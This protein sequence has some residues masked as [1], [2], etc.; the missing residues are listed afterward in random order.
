[1]IGAAH[2]IDDQPNEAEQMADAMLA[3]V[4]DAL[5]ACLAA[6]LGAPLMARVERILGKMPAAPVAVV[7]PT[8]ESV[9]DYDFATV[10]LP[11]VTAAR[12]LSCLKDAR[13][14]RLTP[15]QQAANLLARADLTRAMRHKEG[16]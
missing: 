2:R 8:S 10:T 12:I 4:E 9:G 7:L 1:M 5:R 3:L 15:N 6:G 14:T 13:S 16:S 11:A